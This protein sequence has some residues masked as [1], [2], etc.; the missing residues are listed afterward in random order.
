MRVLPTVGAAC[1]AGACLN[2]HGFVGS[3]DGKVGAMSTPQDPASGLIATLEQ[4]AVPEC[5]DL[6]STAVVGRVGLVVDELPEVLPVNYAL[7]GETVLFRTA[8]GT[9]LNQAALQVVAFEVDHVEERTHEGW[10][11]LVQGFARDIGD[12]VNPN[13]ERIRQLSLVAWAP[14]ARPRWFQVRPDKVTG[15]RLRVQPGAL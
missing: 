7:D 12:A 8:E 9:L 14:G 11:V 3:D 1:A 10:S 5:W 15:R 2:K 13:S 6:L 4:L